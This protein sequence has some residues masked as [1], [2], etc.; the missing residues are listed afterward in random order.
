MLF[1]TSSPIPVLACLALQLLLP[2]G[3]S[4]QQANEKISILVCA[5]EIVGEF[6][7]LHLATGGKPG[8]KAAKWLD[9]PLNV[10]TV[11]QAIEYEGP[12]T[13]DF[14]ASSTA[15]AKP[16]AKTELPGNAKSYLLVFL[17]NKESNGYRVLPIVD[18]DFPYGS[19]LLLNCSTFP[20]AVDI[21]NQKKVLQPGMRTNVPGANGR[22]QDVN[23]YASIHDQIRLIRST[24][25]QLDANQ[26]EFV[27]FYSQP[28]TDLVRSKHIMTMRAEGAEPLK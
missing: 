22:S 10:F 1:P 18:S 14:L 5:A 11:S 28:G 26:R 23:I 20:V 9:I 12:R 19:Y 25:W 21:A 15:D 17:P 8:T 27:M 13:L 3:L 16:V 24:C 7:T 6:H 2:A 4:A